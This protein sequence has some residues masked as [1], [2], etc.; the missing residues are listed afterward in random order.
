MDKAD[1]FNGIR[2]APN[3]NLRMSPVDAV[4]YIPQACPYV[5]FIFFLQTAGMARTSTAARTGW[6]T[7]PPRFTA[8]W[9][10]GPH[11]GH[12]ESLQCPTTSAF[13]VVNGRTRAVPRSAAGT[14]SHIAALRVVEAHTDWESGFG[15]DR[16]HRLCFTQ[17]KN[18][19]PAGS[20]P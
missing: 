4:L 7:S 6:R 10:T 14:L 12:I 2:R 1:L 16:N 20:T 15:S 9:D 19:K 18:P 5:R 3:Q 17:K 13:W 8:N 11:C